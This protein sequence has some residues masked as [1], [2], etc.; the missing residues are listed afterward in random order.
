MTALAAIAASTALPP[1]SRMSAPASEARNCGVETMPNFETTI[2]RPCPGTEENCCASIITEGTHNTASHAK[3]LISPLAFPRFD[4]S[5]AEPGG[6][7]WP[8]ARRTGR[9]DH[10][11]YEDGTLTRSEL[12]S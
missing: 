8:R 10:I 3:R 12:E 6:R 5:I 1:S 9:K 4:W 7:V 11:R 2:E